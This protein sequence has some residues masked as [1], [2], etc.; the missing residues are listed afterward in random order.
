MK[1]RRILFSTKNAYSQDTN[2]IFV[3][4]MKENCEYQ[5]IHCAE[6]RKMLDGMKF[7]PNNIESMKDL[8]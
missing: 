4:A 8:A 1:Y 7:N 3:K 6:Y 2:K 5:Y